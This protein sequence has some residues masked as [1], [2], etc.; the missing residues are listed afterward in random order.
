MKVSFSL[1]LFLSCCITFSQNFLSTEAINNADTKSKIFKTYPLFSSSSQKLNSSVIEIATDIQPISVNQ[2]TLAAIQEEKP[3]FI[4]FDII[5]NHEILSVK[6]QRHQVVSDD[7]R[8]RNQNDEILNYTPGLYYRGKVNGKQESMVV[9]SFFEKSLNGMIS[10]PHQG[11]RIVAQLKNKDQYIIYNDAKMTVKNDFTCD[12]DRIEQPRNLIP[13]SE[14]DDNSSLTENCVRVFYELTNDIYV[15]NSSSVDE[16]INWI[17]SVHNIVAVLYSDSDITTVLSDVLIWQEQDPY[18]GSN[19]D[20]LVN[21]RENRIA[22]NGDLGHLLD[23]PITGGVAYLN[24]LCSEVNYAFSGLSLNYQELPTYSWT[25]M[26]VAHEM[27]HSLGSPHTHACFWNGD[28]SAIDSCGPN[29][30]FSEGCDDGEIPDEGGTIMSYCHL[31]ATGINLGLGFHPQVRQQ[32]IN[33]VE[34]SS[35]LGSDCINSCMRTVAGITVDQLDNDTFIV[36]IEDVASNSWFYSVNKIDEQRSFEITDTSSFEV[37]EAIEPNTYYEVIAINI[38]SNGDTGNFFRKIYLT[39]DNWCDDKIF[40]DAG[41]ENSNY[42]NFLEYSKTFYP[43]TTDGKIKFTIND[44][45]LENGNDFLT[46][47][48]GETTESPV[49]ED[50]ELTGDNLVRTEFEATNSAGAIT[51]LFTSNESIT[52]DGWSILVSCETLSNQDFSDKDISIYPNPFEDNL[53]IKSS[54][55]LDK[56]VVNDM[57]GRQVYTQNITS[58]TKTTLDLSQLNSGIYFVTLSKNGSKFIKRIIKK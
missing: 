17:T 40:T 2:S 52:S 24:S 49:F 38:C 1:L 16:T 36:D 20:K 31:D 54:L 26:V 39:D 4:Q 22:F 37:N 28:S 8:V 45:D 14:F 41:G 46:L 3:E 18:T 42:F 35:C 44:F 13:Q 58:N 51:V 43:N 27:G 9:F 32:M 57:T 10:E 53:I 30:G 19:L 29:N 7:F 15:D 56:L 50:G 23:L 34:G 33:T 6:M 25:I 12:V 55:N 11:N 5:H 47:F 48:D 21:F